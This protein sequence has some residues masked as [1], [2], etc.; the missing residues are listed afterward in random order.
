MNRAPMPQN[1][2]QIPGLVIFVVAAF[3]FFIFGVPRIYGAN[4]LAINTACIAAC[5]VLLAPFTYFSDEANYVYRN[6]G[7]Q[8]QSPAYIPWSVIKG[9]IIYTGSFTRWPVAALLLLAAYKAWSCSVTHRYTRKLSIHS[10]LKNNVEVIPALAPVVNWGSSLLDEPY[11]E[12]PWRTARTPLQFAVENKVLLLDGKPVPP[13]LVFTKMGNANEKSELLKQPWS[14]K[15][16]MD[17]SRLRSIL[18]KQLGPSLTSSFDLPD[19]QKG[20]AAAFMAFGCGNKKEA[21]ALLDQMNVSFRKPKDGTSTWIIDTSGADEL[22]KK[23]MND[24]AVKDTTQHHSCF[25]STYLIALLTFA[26]KKGVLPP[27][28]FLWLRPLD[29]PLWYTLHQVGGRQPWAE[30]AG[31]WN[32]YQAEEVLGASIEEPEISEAVRGIEEALYEEGWLP[33]L[34]NRD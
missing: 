26:R 28:Q 13:K 27:A 4:A 7:L 16:S 1:Q 6:F 19:Y 33:Q 2:A 11:D 9:L 17:S 22:L 18:A 32:H 10:L 12:G 23:H 25:V 21:Q 14:N 15:T 31:P 34:S 8:Y 3:L 24:D 29:K 5:K 30:G 20:L